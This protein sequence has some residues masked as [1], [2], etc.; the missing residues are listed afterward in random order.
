MMLSMKSWETIIIVLLCFINFTQNTQLTKSHFSSKFTYQIQ[1]NYTLPAGPIY[2]KGW[3]KYTTFEKIKES[4]P[5]D[6][7]KN[8]AFLEQMKNAGELDLSKTD[9]IG[10]IN[11]P[12]EDH[13]FFILTDNSLNVLSSRKVNFL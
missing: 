10:Y 6:F 2:A 4:K 9:T 5:N 13:F 8:P 12:D 7:N 3:L 1:K 11:I